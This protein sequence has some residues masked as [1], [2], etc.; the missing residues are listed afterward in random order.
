MAILA[1]NLGLFSLNFRAQIRT[2]N[3]VFK[4]NSVYCH[5]VSNLKT[6][7]SS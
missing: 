3:A 5:D 2:F 4:Q 7:I 6:F 1:K